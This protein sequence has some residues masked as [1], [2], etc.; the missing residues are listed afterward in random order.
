MSAAAFNPAKFLPSVAYKKAGILVVNTNLIN[1]EPQTA[2]N[3]SHYWIAPYKCQVVSVDAVWSVASASGTLQVE[4]L[5]GTTAP[6]SGTNLL[7]SS[8]ST[9]A[10]ANTVT[11]GTLSTTGA[12]VQLAA[13]NRLGLVNGGSVASITDLVVTCVLVPIN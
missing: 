2:G 11:A 3:Y 5:T 12:T 13:G 6:K 8:I 7:S 10:T 4:K 1:A 9:A